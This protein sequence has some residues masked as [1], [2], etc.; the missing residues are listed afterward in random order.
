MSTQNRADIVIAADEI[1]ALIHAYLVDSGWLSHPVSLAG[2]GA[3]LMAF[4]SR[5]YTLGLCFPR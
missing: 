5:I 4:V 3:R 2:F 1:N